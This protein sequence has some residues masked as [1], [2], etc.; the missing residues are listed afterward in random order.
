M[1]EEYFQSVLN[2]YTGKGWYEP[3]DTRDELDWLRKQYPVQDYIYPILE[4]K[5][6]NVYIDCGTHM[7]QGFSQFVK[8]YNINSTW[9][10]YAFEANP[11]VYQKSNEIYN[12]YIS[13][14]FN[15][16][17]LNKAVYDKTELVTVNCAYTYTNDYTHLG[18][19]VLENPPEKDIKYND[20]FLYNDAQLMIGA[21][22]FSDFIINKFDNSH[23]IILKLD[24]EGSEFKVLDDIISSNVYNYFDKIYVE[25]HERFFDNIEF[26]EQKIKYYTTFFK[27]TNVEF[28]HGEDWDLD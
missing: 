27:Q 22:K 10:C 24:I 25:F 5:R 16:T 21:I 9:E 11:Y 19:N 8:K 3:N 7:F 15:I 20:Q 6:K 1:Y 18:S 26:Y 4:Q 14:G 28:L 13:A 2:I 17:H 23:R 12:Q